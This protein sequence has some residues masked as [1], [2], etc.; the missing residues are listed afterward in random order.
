MWRT[1]SRATWTLASER[2]D[3]SGRLFEALAQPFAAHALNAQRLSMYLSIGF[4]SD[5][6]EHC[7]AALAPLEP[8]VPW[9]G[10]FLEERDRCYQL[11]NDPHAAQARADLEAFLANS[12]TTLDYAGALKEGS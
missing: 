8:F 9:D 1:C 5:F 11:H 4:A 6:A 12:P 3:L 7:V 2:Q 10:R